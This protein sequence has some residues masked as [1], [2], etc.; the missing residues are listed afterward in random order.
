M[1]LLETFANASRR[2]Y[3]SGAAPD[4]L[5]DFELIQTITLAGDGVMEFT[6]IPQTYKHLQLRGSYRDTAASTFGRFWM[7]LNGDAS[8]VY[9][10]NNFNQS[11]SAVTL[12]DAMRTSS[13]LGVGNSANSGW[14]TSITI[15]F[16]NYTDTS[17]WQTVDVYYGSVSNTAGGSANPGYMG[18]SYGNNAAISSIRFTGTLNNNLASGSRLSLYG[19]KG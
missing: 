18:G 19:I 14:F 4:V 7:R 11:G 1:P 12:V 13:N 17:Y 16:P 10:T 6:S 3:T 9:S 2:G 15:T 8:T 5:G